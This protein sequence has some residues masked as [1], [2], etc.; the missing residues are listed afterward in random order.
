MAGLYSAYNINRMSPSTTFLI[1]EKNKKSN[2]LGGRAGNETFCGAEVVTGA[3]IGRKLK[4]K[5]LLRLLQDLSIKTEEM[6][7]GPNY[8]ATLHSHICDIPNTM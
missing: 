8:A 3:G 1:L 6:T 4:D 2:G 5:L 7:F